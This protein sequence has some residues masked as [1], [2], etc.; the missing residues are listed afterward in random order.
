VTD[1]AALDDWQ[2]RCKRLG[3]S[4]TAPRRAILA[5]LLDRHDACDA[6]TLLQEARTHIT[7]TSLGTVYRFL[8]EMEQLGLI[9]ARL[10]LHGRTRW[11]LRHPSQASS[12]HDHIEIQAVL[13]QLRHFMNELEK[14]GLVTRLSNAQESGEPNAANTPWTVLTT[15]VERL[16]YR[17]LNTT[18]C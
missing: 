16:G 1:A 18:P 10:Q 11:Y 3:L 12:E 8:R 13:E 6:V 4:M 14:L 5:A 15:M 7:S 9:Q 17:L 2:Q